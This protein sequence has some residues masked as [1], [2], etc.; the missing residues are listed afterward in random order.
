MANTTS[1]KKAARASRR[2]RVVNERRKRTM[3]SAVK[4]FR[5]SATAPNLPNVFQAIDKALKRGVIKKN[6]A[7][8]MKSKL[9][10]LLA[11]K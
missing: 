11:A 2:K 7:A 1:A 3:R 5:K 10:K 9:S 8:R 6:A 4:D